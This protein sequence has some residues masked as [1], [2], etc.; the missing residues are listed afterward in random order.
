MKDFFRYNS[1]TTLAELSIIFLFALACLSLLAPLII[2]TSKW[3]YYDCGWQVSATMS[4]VEDGD[5]DLKNQL[6]NKIEK[7]ADQIALGNDGQ[8][9]PLHEFFLSLTA[10][11]LYL[12]FGFV[13]CL[14]TNIL[15][16]AGIAPLVFLLSFKISNKRLPAYLATTLTVLS[17][18][19]LALT[20]SFSV[21]VFGA[22]LLL[23]S[24]TALVYQ[25]YSLAGLVYGAA[26]MARLFNVLALPA[27][28]ILAIGLNP[29]G[30]LSPR[31]TNKLSVLT[32][33]VLGASPFALWFMISNN[34]MFGSPL[35][36]SYHNW[37]SN[38]GTP[39]SHTFLFPDLVS[40]IAIL[41]DTKIG[42]LTT[43]PVLFLSI[44]GMPLLYRTHRPLALSLCVLAISFIGLASSYQGFPGTIGNRYLL[45]LII[46]FSAPCASLLAYLLKKATPRTKCS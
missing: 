24:V 32:R 11:P 43:A 4:I 7:T 30:K 19:I 44:M 34:Q 18:P 37:M 5:L 14:L 2:D 12:V 20:Y 46:I 35:S 15:I 9:Y 36:T 38:S 26:V 3:F 33:F 40:L 23:G 42:L 8:W 39:T 28:L 17:P 13:G 1:A 22:M 10:V 45:S 27:L 25:R 16:T 6:Q 41:F 31:S 21:D 29:T